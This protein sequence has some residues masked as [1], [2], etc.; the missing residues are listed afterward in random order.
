LGAARVRAQATPTLPPG[1]VYLSVIDSSIIQE[2]RYATSRNFTAASVPGYEAGECILLRSVAQALKL[3]QDN[4]RR[5]VRDSGLLE[6]WTDSPSD[7][8][9]MLCTMNSLRRTSP[10]VRVSAKAKYSAFSRAELLS[11]IVGASTPDA[12]RC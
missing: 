3:V 12:S 5:L 2:I 10:A 7:W 6:A 8:A 4:L 9:S 1:F 11:S